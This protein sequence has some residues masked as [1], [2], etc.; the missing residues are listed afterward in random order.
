MP[1]LKDC[2]FRLKTKI[3][4]PRFDKTFG[5]YRDIFQFDIIEQWNDPGDAGAIFRI[6]DGSSLE[7]YRGEASP[8]G[9]SLQFRVKDVDAFAFLLGDRWPSKGP[10]DRPWG[11]RYLYL[12]DPAGVD[13]VV[14]SG[15]D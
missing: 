7:I 9:V 1:R 6:A 5:F 15:G 4:T 13:I 11:S 12:T 8:A 14:F 3:T 10:V 2:I